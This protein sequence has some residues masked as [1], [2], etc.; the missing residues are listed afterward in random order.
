MSCAYSCIK[1]NY[2]SDHYND[3][4]RHVNKKKTCLK[5]LESF[6]YSDDQ[7][8]VLTLL[9]NNDKNNIESEIEHLKNSNSMNK[10]KTD[11][12]KSI[13]NI[14]KKKLKKCLY[15]QKE[16]SKIND[17]KKHILLN[18]FY[19]EIQKNNFENNKI[20]KINTNDISVTGDEN[21]INNTI[22]NNTTNIYKIEIKNPIPFDDRWDISKID[23]IYKERLIFS[24]FMYSKL[25]EEIL[26][27][28]INLNVIIDKDND[29]GIVYKNDIDKYIQMRSKDIVDNTMLKLKNH[30]IDINNDAKYDSLSECIDCSKK[31]I[32]EKHQN[33]NNN[34]IIKQSVKNIISTIFEN[35]KNNALDISLNINNDD[36]P[37][38]HIEKGY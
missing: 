20:L 10:S 23:A 5:N 1:C 22:N 37:I 18:C 8:L 4:K 38:T 32:E 26:K 24:N 9:S 12:I 34:K 13:N 29:S 30:L 27:N 7:I 15:C 25:L 17:L 14:E 28:E 16:F 33:Y 36:T 11:L 2:K 3:I 19:N 35:K 31:I 6:K 21:V